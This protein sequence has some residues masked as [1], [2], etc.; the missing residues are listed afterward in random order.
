MKSDPVITRSQTHSLSLERL[1]LRSL[2]VDLK[3]LPRAR[4]DCEEKKKKSLISRIIPPITSR[5]CLDVAPEQSVF[6]LAQR[7]S[8]ENAPK[9]KGKYDTCTTK[10]YFKKTT[11]YKLL[12][13]VRF[14]Q[15]KVS[16]LLIWGDECHG[17][18]SFVFFLLTCVLLV[19]QPLCIQV[20]DFSFTLL[21]FVCSPV[22]L[23]RPCSSFCLALFSLLCISLCFFLDS[24]LPVFFFFFYCFHC[25]FWTSASLLKLAFCFITCRLFVL[26][27][28]PF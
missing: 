15:L 19:H 17:F 13:D 22:L 4:R 27:L 26:H 20:C 18:G 11:T 9:E 12:S 7:F 6:L 21:L 28:G 10:C 14:I 24:S 3:R 25:V 2:R 16:S 5:L 1:H 8:R 23:C